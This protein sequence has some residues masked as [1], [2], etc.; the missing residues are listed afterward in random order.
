VL[1]VSRR[2]GD[3]LRRRALPKRSD[4][5]NA[6]SVL[7]APPAG[8]PAS[9]RRRPRR[10]P[11]ATAAFAAGACGGGRARPSPE[12]VRA[13]PVPLPLPIPQPLAVA[14]V[15]ACPTVEVHG[16]NGGRGS[17]VGVTVVL[18]LFHGVLCFL[19]LVK[20]LPQVV[21]LEGHPPPE[22]VRRRRAPTSTLQPVAS[23]AG[24]QDE[25]PSGLTRPREG[26]EISAHAAVRD[27]ARRSGGDAAAHIL[28]VPAG[29]LPR[30]PRARFPRLR[31]HARPRCRLPPTRLDGGACHHQPHLHEHLS[32]SSPLSGR[33][34]S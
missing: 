28:A 26:E 27:P 25:P 20:K 15:V 18:L 23:A 14:V 30:L 16:T 33:S 34:W 13:P 17:P 6:A 5:T 7:P 32:C 10:Q 4:P 22:Q 31:R 12:P 21:F 29:H 1:P 11:A 24:A 8:A 9:Q 19:F 3:V 2:G